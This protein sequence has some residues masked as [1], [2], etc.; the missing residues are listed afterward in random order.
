MPDGV[1]VRTLAGGEPPLV[2]GPAG[3]LLASGSTDGTIKLWS[4]PDGALRKTLNGSSHAVY[5]VA[6]SPDGKLLASGGWDK[7]ISLWSLPDG[8]LLKTLPG[9]A[10]SVNSVAIGPNGRL[11][12]SG[13]SDGT[14]K[15]WSLPDGKPLSTCLMDLDASTTDAK[16]IRYTRG[17]NSFTQ[18]CGSPVP[19]GAVCTCNCVPGKLCPCVGHTSGGG[20]GGGGGHYWYPN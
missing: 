13:G 19:A 15:L 20:G 12:A 3:R 14:I 11:L 18:G 17:G 4:L 5:S 10:Y 6:I 9:H 1:L 16:G 7:T 8:A 2:I